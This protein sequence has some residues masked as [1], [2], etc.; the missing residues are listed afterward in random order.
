M[1]AAAELVDDLVAAGLVVVDVLEA[2]Q[3]RVG[4]GP[5]GARLLAGLLLLLAARPGEAAGERREA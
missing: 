2:L 3:G 5:A 4:G 1:G